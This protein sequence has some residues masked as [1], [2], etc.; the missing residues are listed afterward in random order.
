MNPHFIFNSL[1]SIENFIMENEK[2]LASDYLNKF[3]HL[4]RLILDSSRNELIP[5]S[6]DMEALQ[7]Y[8]DIEQLRFNHKFEYQVKIDPELQGSHYSV[9]ALIIQ[10]YIRMPSSMDWPIVNI[11]TLS[12]ESRSCRRRHTI[13]NRG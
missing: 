4:I 11:P 10:P 8:V 2:R 3:A 7:L 6:K 13:Y 12:G 5:F 1:N 9:P